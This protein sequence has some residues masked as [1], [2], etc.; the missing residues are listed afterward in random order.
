MAFIISF[1]AMSMVAILIP[2][3]F[4]YRDNKRNAAANKEGQ[5]S[6]EG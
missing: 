1:C 3:Y 6:K 4:V 5:S 2:L